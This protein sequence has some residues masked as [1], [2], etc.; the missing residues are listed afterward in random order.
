MSAV[1]NQ[2]V[3]YF[4]ACG[5]YV[6]IGYS[7]GDLATRLKSLPRGV[8]CPED[9][10]DSQPVVLIR[11]IPGCL[12]RDERR[13]HGLFAKYRVAGEWFRYDAR[14]IR[15]LHRLQYV[16]YKQMLANLRQARADLKRAR[17]RKAAA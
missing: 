12:I 10:D 1:S 9:L 2:G 11:T 4:A 8:I 7:S 6:K 17:A 16:T 13:L 5:Q 14:F 15:H 3:V